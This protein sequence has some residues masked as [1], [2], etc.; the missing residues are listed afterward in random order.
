MNRDALR[1]AGVDLREGV[2]L[3]ART[4]LKIG[5]P[6]RFFAEVPDA[7]AL[8]LLLAG[9]A[10]EGLPVLP[11]G[12]GSNVLVADEGFDG[13]V[14]VLGGS[15]RTFAIEGDLVRC[16]AG[17]SLM[18]LAVATRDAGLSGLENL[19]GIPSSIGG[20]I[21]INAGSYGSQLFDLL[22]DVETVSRRGQRRVRPAGGIARGYRWSALMEED[23][24]I[25]GGTLRLT[26]RPPEE[27]RRRFDEVTAKRKGALPRQPNA[28]SIFKNPP[29]LFAGKLLEE[30]GMKGRRCGGAAVSDVHA[31]VIVNLGGATARDVRTLMAQMAAA[32]KERSNVT[33]VPEIEVLGPDGRR[34]PSV[35]SIE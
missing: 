25:A 30:C 15:F 9:A 27:I 5:G 32:V 12:K 4:T 10:A 13:V 28:G 29:G 17:V 33:L 11:L 3:A 18:S 6:A 31:N 35:E 1:A 20:A 26:P 24:V 34:I 16:G 23:D 8:G 2:P 21:R 19:S 7:T 14:F 22:V